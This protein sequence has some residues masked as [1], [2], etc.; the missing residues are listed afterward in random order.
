MKT[1]IF[2]GST[3]GITREIAHEIAKRLNVAPQDIHDVAATAPSAVAG[4]D[5]LILGSSTWGA[6]ELQDD[7]YDFLDGLEAMDLRGKTI[8]VYGCG[9]ESMADTFNNAAGIIYH[10]LQDTGARFTGAFNTRGYEFEHSDAVADDGT[11]VGLLLDNVNHEDLTPGRIDA[12][13]ESLKL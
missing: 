7:W 9:D 4:Y 5:A 2:Y 11:A 1:G 10:R 13:V 3:T 8:A 12:W 6:G